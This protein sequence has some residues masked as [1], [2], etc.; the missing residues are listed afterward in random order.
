MGEE[1]CADTDEVLGGNRFD[2]G[3]L[4]ARFFTS[5]RRRKSIDLRVPVDTRSSPTSVT[6]RIRSIDFLGRSVFELDVEI[7]P[8]S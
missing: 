2:D 4:K 3:E 7:D 6:T 1:Y 8:A 5:A